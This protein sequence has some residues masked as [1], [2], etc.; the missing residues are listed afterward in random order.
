MFGTAARCSRPALGHFAAR[1]GLRLR[2]AVCPSLCPLR[3]DL[4][5]HEAA[6]RL[7]LL[8]QRHP[9]VSVFSLAEMT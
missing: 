8:T 5:P 6:P 2:G 4:N 3:A 7:Y 9:P 1:L